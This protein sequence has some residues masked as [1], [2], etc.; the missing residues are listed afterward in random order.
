MINKILICVLLTATL[1][2][3]EYDNTGLPIAFADEPNHRT[4]I[5]DAILK[6][7]P[8]CRFLSFLNARSGDYYSYECNENGEIIYSDEP[9]RSVDPDR[10][11]DL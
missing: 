9:Y 6:K 1:T 3:C 10:E 2:S 8:D 7:D 4:T 5:C 11:H